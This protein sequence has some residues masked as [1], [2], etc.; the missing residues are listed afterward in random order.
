MNVQEFLRQRHIPFEVLDHEPT[1]DAQHMAHAVH[2]K[3]ETVAKPVLLRADHGYRYVT[4]IVPASQKI[5]LEEAGRSLGQCELRLACE[6][7]VS[8]VCPDCEFGI[9]LPFGSQYGVQTLV[10]SSLAKNNEIV[11]EGNTH[12]QSIRMKFADFC[13]LESPLIVPLTRPT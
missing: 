11:F 9:L 7:E 3:G 1:F 5:D 13:Q 8:E 6:P 4:A 2:A 10:D 12:Q